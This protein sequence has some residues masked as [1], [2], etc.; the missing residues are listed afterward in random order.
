MSVEVGA[1][2]AGAVVLGGLCCIG[3]VLLRRLSHVACS[4]EQLEQVG[5]ATVATEQRSVTAAVSLLANTAPR[6]DSPVSRLTFQ[7]SLDPARFAEASEAS[8]IAGLG[9]L[10]AS[11]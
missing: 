5:M 7:E 8:A 11:R 9:D 2:L 10:L 4:L 3:A 1:L 6:F